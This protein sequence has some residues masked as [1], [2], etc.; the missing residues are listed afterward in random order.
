MHL[1]QAEILGLI[2]T[3]QSQRKLIFQEI[4]KLPENCTQYELAA[5][6]YA[7]RLCEAVFNDFP[8]MP[9]TEREKTVYA[10]ILAAKKNY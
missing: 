4:E 3:N 5:A 10:R 6:R 7:R 2:F 8:S 9:E 1:L